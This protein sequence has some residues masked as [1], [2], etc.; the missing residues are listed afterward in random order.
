M[1]KTYTAKQAYYFK[2]RP[3]RVFE[4]LTEPK[5]LVKWFLSKAKVDPK[6]GGTFSFDWIGGYRMMSRLKKYNKD[7]AVSF[8]WIDKLKTGEIAKTTASFEVKK[9][10]KGTLLELRHS[11][12]KD[13]EHFADCSSRW[14]YYLTNMKSVLDNGKDLRSRYDW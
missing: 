13:P 2:A 11:G 7:K 10:G 6:T 1:P 9:R 4:A 8:S 12:F 5:P 3:E 14:A